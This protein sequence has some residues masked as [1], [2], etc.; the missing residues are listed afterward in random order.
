MIPVDS[1]DP[2]AE[3]ELLREEIEAYSESLAAK[4]HCVML[5]RAD[6]LGP[7]TD[8]PTIGVAGAWGTFVVSSVA[9]I[10]LTDV[11]EALW[12]E[13]R[14]TVHAKSSVTGEEAEWRP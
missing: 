10:G 7:D 11:L 5:T 9:R 6:L 1:D 12:T 3:Y 8:P 4:P 14:K 2:Q 13:V